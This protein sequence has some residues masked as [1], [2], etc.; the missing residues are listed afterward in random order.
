MKLFELNHQTPSITTEAL[1]IPEFK[2]L[3][4][5]DKSKDKSKAFNELS[6][7]YF[8]TDYKSLY[9]TYDDDYRLEKLGQ[10]FMKDPKFKPDKDMISAMDKYK[11][12]Q[13]TPSMSFLEDARN[14][15]SSI[16]KYFRGIDWTE[17][18]QSGKATY[19]IKEVTS[20]LKDCEGILTTL[21][22]LTEKV[23]KEQSLNGRARGGSTGGL[24]ENA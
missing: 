14:A 5:R 1:L 15:V 17:R 2:K 6:Y 9:L 23:A 21:D 24:L 10:D 20:A 13:K 16:R 7:I 8:A 3:W 11:E 12:L 19:K 18:D 22:K 4:D